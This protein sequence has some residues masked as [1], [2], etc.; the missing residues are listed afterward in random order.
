MTPLRTIETAPTTAFMGARR[1]VMMGARRVG[2]GASACGQQG[3]GGEDEGGEAD[4]EG[5]AVGEEREVDVGAQEWYSSDVAV[6]RS[7][8]RPQCAVENEH[9][10]CAPPRCLY[11]LLLSFTCSLAPPPAKQRHQRAWLRLLRCRHICAVHKQK[12]LMK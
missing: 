4:A 10:F 2:A 1:T 12:W 9:T 11:S 5:D 8:C 6:S 3:G 7:Q